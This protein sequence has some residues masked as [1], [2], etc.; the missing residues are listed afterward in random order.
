MIRFATAAAILLAGTALATAQTLDEDIAAFINAPGFD[1]IDTMPLELE[2]AEQFLDTA[3]I[4]PGSAVGPIE[5]A[6]M[7]ADK[8][9]ASTRTRTTISYGEI[10]AEEDGAP[11]PVS[12]IEV[13]HYNL[14]PAIR[15][16]TAEAYGE[17][18]TAD[19]EEFGLGDHMAWRF[20]FH[21]VMGSTAGLI[22]ASHQVISEKQASK[23]DCAGRPCLALGMDFDV[24]R[25][26]D[27]IEVNL[28][29]WPTLYPTVA[30]D[31]AT[32]AHAIAQL[33]A[34]G[35]SANAE[36]GDYQWTGGERPEAANGFEPYRFIDIDRNLGQEWS[37]DTVWT[38]TMLNDDAIY[39][40]AFRR[41][42]IVGQLHWYE[43]VEPRH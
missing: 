31:I 23:D 34:L 16:E 27:E 29:E 20:V 39:S 28:P 5:K 26:W 6:M 14:G 18:N 25:S 41:L 37:I 40:I 21:P 42:D 2:L 32:P 1:A 22:S 24:D 33:A 7:I 38:D 13:R 9:I 10:I 35:W 43:S 15:L 11:M 36:S 17:E 8:A 19:L 4:A 3:A 12:F 30:E